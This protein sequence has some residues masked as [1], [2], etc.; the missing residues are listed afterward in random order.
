MK[1]TK[2]TFE[3]LPLMTTFSQSASVILATDPTQ[4]RWTVAT[5]LGANL[6][7]ILE[8]VSESMLS[9]LKNKDGEKF[10]FI[11]SLNKEDG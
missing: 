3:S 4:R 8:E 5:V 9:A 6:I 2:T 1:S 7:V 10:E 11:V